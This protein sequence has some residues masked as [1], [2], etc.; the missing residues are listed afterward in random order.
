MRP[1]RL[2]MQAFGP[3]A[4]KEVVDFQKFGEVSL[5]LIHGPTGAG[6]TTVLDA[7]CFALFGQTS[8]NERD[9]GQ[10]RS[11]HA[12]PDVPTEVVFDFRFRGEDYRVRRA[13]P[14][15]RP[16]KRGTGTTREPH[17]ATLYRLADPGG[18]SSGEPLETQP[19]KV[20]ARVEELLG[21]TA[22]QFRQVVVLPQGR[23]REVLTADSASREAIFAKLFH[24]ELYARVASELKDRAA[25]LASCVKEARVRQKTRL[26]RF[27]VVDLAQLEELARRRALDAEAAAVAEAAAR[28]AR[29]EAERA[30]RRA[31][32]IQRKLD[33]RA[34]AE[35][36]H[37][38]VVAETSRVEATQARLRAARA[39]RPLEA[40]RQTFAESERAAAQAAER[41]AETERRVAQARA[42]HER[43]KQALVAERRRD[44]QRVRASER[45]T[46]L[47]SYAEPVERLGAEERRRVEVV[48]ALD[49]AEAAEADARRMLARLREEATQARGATEQN[50]VRAARVE[51]LEAELER[52]KRR[53][54][55]AAEL[56]RQEQEVARS[57][58]ELV[59]AEARAAQAQ[60]A[61]EARRREEDALLRRWRAAQATL[62][63]EALADG[64]PCPVCGATEHPH[65]AVGAEEPVSE[66][67]VEA[68]RRAREEA[69]RRLRAA[70]EEL[71]DR[72]R[73]LDDKRE[74]AR[75]ARARLQQLPAID[76]EVATL[77]AELRAA[78]V[79]RAQQNALQAAEVAAT[80]AA[81]QAAAVLEARREASAE[82]RL[83]LAQVEAR[84]EELRR[85]LPE[86]FR[87]AAAL[88]RARDEAEDEAKALREAL[89]RAVDAERKAE[90]EAQHAEA[91]LE[92][93]TR[94][95][96]EARQKLERDRAELERRRHEA[97]FEDTASLAAALADVGQI[98]TLEATVR[99][100]A[101][102]LA[103]AEVRLERA[104][105]DAEGLA[106]PALERLAKEADEALAAHPRA[107]ERLAEA[108]A[109][110]KEC[111]EALASL[112]EEAAASKRLEE[113]QRRAAHLAEVA[114]GRRGNALNLSFQRYVLAVLL[115]EVLDA[116]TRR[117]HTMS[118][119]RYEL[120]RAEGVAHGARAAGLDL[121]V[122]DSHTG[123]PRPVSTLSG[124]EGF[125]AALAL[126]LGL[127][128]VVQ[129]HAGGVQLDALFVDEGFGALDEQ[130][131]RE[132]ID[133][134]TEL[135]EAK[136][137]VGIISHV[138]ELRERIDARLEVRPSDRGSVVRLI[139][140]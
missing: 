50:R 10:M 138:P 70:R 115:D 54:Q 107:V 43:A 57:R 16:R 90:D 28:T 34:R 123:R 92:A 135:N 111:G 15:E 109:A 93:V 39:A 133:V 53:A 48:R 17:T 23:F 60:R 52:A 117:L 64:E 91:T 87:D 8:G 102:R 7:I 83:C 137:L 110:S 114:A 77:D 3:F 4:S 106:P 79:A 101:E 122:L 97:G 126:S 46:V 75:D 29:E 30:Y 86:A 37:A 47:K 40:W 80:R 139:E 1:L 82:A 96:R 105:Q 99:E 35:A 41:Q 59:G 18:E 98:D 2:S 131:V 121:E 49:A 25:T 78:R 136:R 27:G 31:Q 5:F 36:E 76:G 22:Q 55:A 66:G 118:R 63:A 104:R 58:E 134:L 120:R 62:L 65:P 51:V 100:H 26:E 84:I 11:H 45:V 103:V 68:V 21:L 95:A 74:H 112:T 132:A 140:P 94:S 61:L 67:K 72:R 89:E 69:E 129:A 24:T 73:A 128:D 88:A 9:A 20:T 81:E 130:A 124:G 12:R 44:E 116:A 32:E 71:A 6:K 42:A 38:A 125:L 127:V 56:A 19:R 119:G 13:P 14:Q 108:R 85:G 33:E 113:R